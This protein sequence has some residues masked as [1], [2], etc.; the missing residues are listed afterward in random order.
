[1]PKFVGKLQKNEH[2][3]RTTVSDL[4]ATRW[5]DT[6]EIIILNN[7]HQKDETA[8]RRRQKDGTLLEVNCPTAISFYNKIMGGVDSGDQNVR[9]YD[10]DRK[11]GKWWKKV[12]FRL[13]MIAV[14]NGWIICQK[15]RSKKMSLL[16][17]I[18]PL[19]QSLICEGK[20]RAT[21]LFAKRA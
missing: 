4:L 21:K 12:F 2:E 20:A 7:C 6:K 9:I 1:M 8:V 17:F 3:F 19:A 13:V 18:A 15:L 10:L 5:Q 16:E 14:V 11:F